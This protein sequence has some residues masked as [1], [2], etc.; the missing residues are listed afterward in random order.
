MVDF[1]LDYGRAFNN[2]ATIVAVNRSYNDLKRN[3][4]LF[5]K[6]ALKMQ[7]DPGLTLLAVAQRITALAGSYQKVVT[8]SFE[9]WCSG[10][11]ESEV[12]KEQQNAAKAKTPSYPRPA[13]NM[14]QNVKTVLNPLAV[15]LGIE[16]Y[17]DEN[18]IMIVDGGDFAASAA[19]ICRPRGPLQ[20]MDPGPFGTLGV[21][22]GFALGAKL[23]DPEAEIW[24]IWGDG[25]S[26]YSIAEV[27]T[28]RRFGIGVICVIGNDACWSQIEREQI[29][30]LGDNTACM[31][32]Y[33]DYDLISKGFGGDGEAI[34]H[35]KALENEEDNA[36]IRAKE[37]VK[38]NNA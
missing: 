36:F 37:Y 21:G 23:V 28:F 5:W 19:Y 25:S 17:M 11:K 14:K 2:N 7:C 26:G 34:Y 10:L 9:G 1:R 16:K 32:S 20:W 35:K 22:A 31:L 24:L 13:L 6:P 15:C 8:R 29:P 33:C 12:A 3:T 27:D 30:K 38:K 18:A 4:D